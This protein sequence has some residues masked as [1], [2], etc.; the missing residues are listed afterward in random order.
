MTRQINTILTVTNGVRVEIDVSNF[1]RVLHYYLVR[2]EDFT[3]AKKM[4]LIK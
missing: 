2:F 4:L 3:E 1:T